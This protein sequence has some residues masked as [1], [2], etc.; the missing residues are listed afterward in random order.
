MWWT[1]D[2]YQPIAGGI[3]FII[4]LVS[5]PFGSHFMLKCRAP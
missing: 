5:S 1:M 3:F 4:M 2:G